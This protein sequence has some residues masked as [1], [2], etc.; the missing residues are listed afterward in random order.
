MCFRLIMNDNLDKGSQL[1]YIRRALKDGWELM[2]LNTNM[3]HIKEGD[4]K[5]PIRVCTGFL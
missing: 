4:K 3:N 1:P 5:V 2:V